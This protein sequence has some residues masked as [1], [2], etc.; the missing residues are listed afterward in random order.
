MACPTFVRTIAVLVVVLPVVSARAEEKANSAAAAAAEATLTGKGLKLRTGRYILDQQEKQADDSFKEYVTKHK[1][2]WMAADKAL[3]KLEAL[4]AARQKQKQE[5]DS[6]VEALDSSLGGALSNQKRDELTKQRAYFS[7]LANSAQRDLA[8]AQR[9]IARQR[10][11]ANEALGECITQL[12]KA[13]TV[14]DESAA[15]YTVLGLDKEVQEAVEKLQA[16][17]AK[18]KLKV[19]PSSAFAQLEKRI[20][21]EEN[22]TI[23]DVLSLEQ[24]EGGSGWYLQIGFGGAATSD[25][26]TTFKFQLDTGADGV[27]M[28][29]KLAKD[30]GLSPEK[31]GKH[32]RGKLANGEIATGVVVSAPVVKVGRFEVHNVECFVFDERYTDASSLFGIEVMNGFRWFIDPE[33]KTLTLVERDKAKAK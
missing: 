31:S 9:D 11:L 33:N 4:V 8:L 10:T 1:P 28:P 30:L 27:T 26:K 18:R 7:N 23:P 20:K 14:F 16:E 24:A 2:K 3:R 15:A 22:Q 32:T 19:S 29:W 25:S 13:R 21:A 17:D 12:Q 5:C 6:R